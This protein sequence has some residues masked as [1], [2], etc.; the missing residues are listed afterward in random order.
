MQRETLH[1]CSGIVT[2]TGFDTIPGLQRIAFVLRAGNALGGGSIVHCKYFYS[3]GAAMRTRG[4]ARLIP[5][6]TSARFAVIA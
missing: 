6:M 1:R 3:R 5:Q 4:S 2:N